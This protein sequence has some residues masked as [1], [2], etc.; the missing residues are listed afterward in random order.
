MMLVVKYGGN[1]MGGGA[2]A[3]IEECAELVRAGQQIVLVHGGGPQI[4]VAV[5]KAGIP[6]RRVAGLRVTDEETLLLTE[7]VLCG[8][9]NKALVRSF[10]ACGVRAAGISGQDGGMLI[11]APIAPIDGESL[12][13]VGEVRAVDTSLIRCI[14]QAGFVPVI[15]PLGISADGSERYNLNA[16]TAAGAIAGALK[17]D[18]YLVVTDVPRVRRN[19]R[20]PASGI[21][22]LTLAE[23][24]ELLA[25]GAF[26]GGMRPKMLAVF[27]AL[28]TGATR[29]I[30]AGGNRALHK[31]IAGDGT[32]VL[33]DH[34][35]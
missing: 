30:I 2:D 34:V 5:K 27:T 23:A 26:D 33:R 29:A 6:E 4:D 1:A 19:P 15:A 21:D 13:F 22:L 35:Q 20:D 24:R 8:Q 16:D 14:L 28:E 32:T 31:A 25:A 3:F 12:G 11:A 10:A 18:R 7:H 17:A 9:V